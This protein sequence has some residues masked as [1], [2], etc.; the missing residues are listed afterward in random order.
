MTVVDTGPPAEVAPQDASELRVEPTIGLEWSEAVEQWGA[1]RATGPAQARGAWLHRA[2]EE[3]VLT[4]YLS[5]RKQKVRTCTSSWC[6]A[7]RGCYGTYRNSNIY[8][9]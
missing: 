7:R 3:Q 8:G 9:Q 6:T 2:P 4:F 5:A 1:E